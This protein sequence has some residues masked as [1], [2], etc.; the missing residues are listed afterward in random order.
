MANEPISLFDKI[1]VQDFDISFVSVGRRKCVPLFS[2]W[3]AT[4]PHQYVIHYI[5]GGV[6]TLRYNNRQVKLQ[7]NDIFVSFPGFAY[8]FTSDKDDPLDYVWLTV[9]GT[10]ADWVMEHSFVTPDKP[11]AA[12]S[13]DLAPLFLD[14]IREKEPN[15]AQMLARY[16]GLYRLLSHI[17][18][19]DAS[20]HDIHSVE[21]DHNAYLVNAIDYIHKNFQQHIGV[22]EL[23]EMLYIS[24]DYLFKLFIR[25]TG[26]SPSQFIASYRVNYSLPLL[27]DRDLSI[28]RISTIC[29]FCDSYHYSRTFKKIHQKTPA[30]YRKELLKNIPSKK[31][32]VL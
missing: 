17:V 16:E 1:S 13:T 21:Y 18:D 3:S 19:H 32:E 24:R 30:Q 29:G 9:Q 14:L 12:Y 25:N 27:A 8:Q 2:G 28:S 10:R 26:M 4:R 7:K 31:G 15:C 22:S 20:E 23:A 6:A 5:L 11:F